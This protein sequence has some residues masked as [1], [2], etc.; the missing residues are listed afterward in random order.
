MFMTEEFS[1]N[2]EVPEVAPQGETQVN[3]ANDAIKAKQDADERNWRAMRLKNA[4]LEKRLKD[5][6]DM[7][8]KILQAQVAGLSNKKPEPDEFDAIGAGEFI[9]KGTVERLVEKKAQ[10]YA[11]E[12]AK[13]EVERH[14]KQQN[15]SQFLDRL[16]RQY[17]DFNDVVNP[18]TLSLLEEKEPELAQT[19]ADLKDPYKMGVQTYKYIKAMNLVQKVPDSRREKETEKQIEKANKSVPSPAA[20]DKRPMAQA[21]KMTDAMKKDLYREMMGYA[22]QASGVPEMS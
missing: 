4:D 14:L 6:E 20:F 3:E 12:I 15:D 13:K 16:S 19:I 10:K 22:N 2:S 18:E 17:S 5:R 11:E 1:Q 9:S 7:M 8:D 21:F